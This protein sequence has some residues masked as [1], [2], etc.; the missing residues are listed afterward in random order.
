MSK[1]ERSATGF[2]VEYA[3]G[4]K[5][6]VENGRFEV[7]NPAGRTVEQRPATSADLARFRGL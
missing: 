3:N 2:E 7:K 1:V 5:V 6:E 4:W